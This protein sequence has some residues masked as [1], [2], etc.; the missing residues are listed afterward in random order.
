MNPELLRERLEAVPNQETVVI[1]EVQ[2]V[3]KILDVVHG[4]IEEKKKV[5]FILTT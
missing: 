4:L 5:Q 1:D 2:K 3:P